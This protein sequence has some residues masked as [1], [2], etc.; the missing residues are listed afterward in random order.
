V[1]PRKADPELSQVC[2]SQVATITRQK[3][4]EAERIIQ[5]NRKTERDKET[6]RDKRRITKDRSSHSPFHAL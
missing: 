5:R 2:A 3:D 4:P 6:K 1:E